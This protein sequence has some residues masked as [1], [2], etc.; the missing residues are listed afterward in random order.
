MVKNES[1][2][3]SFPGACSGISEQFDHVSFSLRT[4]ILRSVLRGIL[5][6]YI[7]TEKIRNITLLFIYNIVLVI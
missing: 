3:S 4:K 6:P 5:I 7:L 1:A 2:A